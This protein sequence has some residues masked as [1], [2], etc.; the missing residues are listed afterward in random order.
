MLQ[1]AANT[2]ALTMNPRNTATAADALGLPDPNL[3]PP[4]VAESGDP[5]ASLRVVHLLARI[6]RGRPVSVAEIVARLNAE[7]LDWAFSPRVVVDVVVQ[8]QANWMADYRTAEG[9]RVNGG[10]PSG[11]S[12]EIEASSRV[13][14]WI[15]GQARR[16][17]AECLQRL[18]EFARGEGRATEG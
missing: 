4:T 16:L 2:L 15:V 6:A 10:A 18:Q 8:L 5:F 7:Y 1:S 3:Q 13:D 14:P 9:I 12:I 11:A 17:E